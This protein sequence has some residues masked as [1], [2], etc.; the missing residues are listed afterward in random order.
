MKKKAIILII[1][2]IFILSLCLKPADGSMDELAVINVSMEASI[3][4]DGLNK[5]MERELAELI[6]AE[7]AQPEQESEKWWCKIKSPIT[8]SGSMR[9]PFF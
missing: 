6:S 7:E 2:G 4:F 9:V 3:F 8:V 5:Q 1:A